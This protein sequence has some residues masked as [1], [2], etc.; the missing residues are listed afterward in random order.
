MWTT[1]ARSTCGASRRLRGDR[2]IYAHELVHAIA[3]DSLVAPA[4]EESESA[5]FYLEGWAE[6]VALLV[7]PGK[8][9]FPLFGSDEDVV[10]AESRVHHLASCET[11]VHPS[12]AGRRASKRAEP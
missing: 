10:H 4:L 6:Y 5:G 11:A 12:S 1:R 2:A 3:Y 9:G 7:D 8:T